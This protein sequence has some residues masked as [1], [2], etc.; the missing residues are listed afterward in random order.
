MKYILDKKYNS[1]DRI[2]KWDTET[3]K[4]IAGRIANE[5]GDNFAY[6]FLTP[7]EGEILELL[8]DILVPQ[9]KN[10]QYIKIAEAIDRDL[11]KD[12]KKVRYGGDPWP[13][14][15]YSKGLAEIDKFAKEDY[16]KPLEDFSAS[17]LEKFVDDILKVDSSN[18]LQRF[19]GKVLSD[20][21]TIYY[22]HPASWNKIGFPGPAY[23]EGYAYLD[24]G[25]ADT[26]E[27]K[28]EK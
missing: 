5:L 1:L 19:M 18:F 27:P 2:E 14:E 13:R 8:V 17:Q 7:A 10:Y 16:G 4:V 22:S 25:E 28:Y 11:A 21:A 3:Q 9:E 15:F 24:C 20:A 26:W 6:D 23:P 12:I